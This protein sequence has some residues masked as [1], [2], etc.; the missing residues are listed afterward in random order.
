VLSICAIQGIVGRLPSGQLAEKANN[1]MKALWIVI[2][3]TI[4]LVEWIALSTRSAS[5]QEPAFDASLGL[6][7]GLTAGV[8][9][10]CSLLRIHEWAGQS[11]ML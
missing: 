10:V 4:A 5:T 6:P 9:N 2:V 8:S 3:V 1:V 11:V 7:L